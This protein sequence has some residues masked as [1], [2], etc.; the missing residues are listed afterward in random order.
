MWKALTDA[1][2]APRKAKQ[3][4]KREN[5]KEQLGVKIREFNEKMQHEVLAKK[6]KLE[7]LKELTKG[8]KRAVLQSPACQRLL[9][10]INRHNNMIRVFETSL[11]ALEETLAN[12]Q[13]QDVHNQTTWMIGS[14]VRSMH[15][16]NIDSADDSLGKLDEFREQREELASLMA[17]AASND[18]VDF[19]ELAGELG[20]DF[21]DDEVATPA[22]VK[23][24]VAEFAE[25]PKTK[26]VLQSEKEPPVVNDDR[27][28]NKPPGYNSHAE[29]A[30]PAKI[31]F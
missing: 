30:E 7:R 15:G 8:K 31:A 3:E 16:I 4:A 13:V 25:V 24:N 11:T 27:N 14:V 17:S 2:A 28:D 29:L 18:C 6:I 5:S 23:V 21:D 1:F 19:D 12:L 9:G 22:P 26:P 20:L 10:G